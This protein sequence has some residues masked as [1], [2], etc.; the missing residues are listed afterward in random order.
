M[1]DGDDGSSLHQ[2]ASGLFEQGFRFGVQAGSRFIENQ[3]WRVF[4]KCT[5]QRE[6]LDLPATQP[7]A[8]LTDDGLIFLRQRFDE[9][10]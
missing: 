3:D 2:A 4:E 1:S 8:T 9:V 10:V 6:T 7:R 5:C